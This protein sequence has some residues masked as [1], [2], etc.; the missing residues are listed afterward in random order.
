MLP[1]GSEVVQSIQGVWRSMDEG[2]RA[3]GDLDMSVRGLIRSFGAIALTLPAAV[4]MIA[5]ERLRHGLSNEAGLLDAPWLAASVIAMLLLSFLAPPAFIVGLFW[6]V[7]RTA[8]GTGFIVAWN[9]SCVLVMFIVAA[10]LA[11][12]A[13]GLVN[14]ALAVVVVAAFAIIAMRL[15]YAVARS[16]LGL[17]AKS[18]AAA[19]GVAFS[20]EMA[21]G[22]TLAAIAS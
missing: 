4:A 22:L 2:E 7:A 12:F 16:A 1:S 19:V 20:V 21:A 8:R 15:R 11:L 9:W 10:P 6:R 18:G 3:L 5:A 17:D 13:A 14:G